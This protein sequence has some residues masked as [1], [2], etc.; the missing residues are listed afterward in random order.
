[1]END[2][3]EALLL[4][5]ELTGE[6]P[7]NQDEQ[8]GCV[9]CGGT[10]PGERYGYAEADPTHHRADCPWVRARAYLEYHHYEALDE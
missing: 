8:G 10:P 5:D 3:A 9:W 4:I 6:T 7:L 1:M 2:I